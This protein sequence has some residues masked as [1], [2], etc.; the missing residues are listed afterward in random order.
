[1][2]FCVFPARREGVVSAAV[3]AR[4]ARA[5]ARIGGERRTRSKAESALRKTRRLRRAAPMRA[6]HQGERR[7][8]GRGARAC[9]CVRARGP[10]RSRKEDRGLVVLPRTHLGLIHGG[11]SC[12]LVGAGKARGLTRAPPTRAQRGCAR[13]R[14]RG[15]GREASTKGHRHTGG[16]GCFCVVRV[17]WSARRDR[18]CGSTGVCEMVDVMR[19]ACG[20]NEVRR[21]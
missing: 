17:G 18:W 20:S 15:R 19:V 9:V 7:S 21:V 3:G 2:F 6:A 14:V 11:P 1:M 12:S 4:P 16:G 5:R 8:R 10:M 13:A